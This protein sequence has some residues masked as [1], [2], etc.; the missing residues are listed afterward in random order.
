MRHTATIYSFCFFL[1]I[2]RP[3]RSTRTDTLFPSTTLFRSRQGVLREAGAAVARSGV[4]ELAADAPVEADAAGDVVHVGADLLAEIGDLV[5][6]GDLGGEEGVAGVL[7]QLGGLQAG[8]ENRRFD[9]VER[10][11]EEHTSELQS[12]MRISYAV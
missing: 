10:R 8:E 6:N 7:G 2:R 3:P 5:D 9:Q 4:Q 1:M 12:L 11:S